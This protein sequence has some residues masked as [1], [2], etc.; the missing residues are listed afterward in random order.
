[1]TVYEV[2]LVS[3]NLRPQEM[4]LQMADTL[5][6]LDRISNDIFNK[7]GSRIQESRLRIQKIHQR[8]EAAQNKIGTMTG[9]R[10]ATRIFSSS[11]FPGVFQSSTVE[12]F[13]ESNIATIKSKPT[14]EN[15]DTPVDS[16]S[17]FYPPLSRSGPTINLL[18]PPPKSVSELLIF[19]TEDLVF[20]DKLVSERIPKATRRKHDSSEAAVDGLLGDAPWSIIQRESGQINPHNYAYIP[21]IIGNS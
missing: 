8:V 20:K 11:R 15:A 2:P 19:N 1:M 6:H 12:L 7:V 16:D 13:S 21:G 17:T 10:K 5:D 18:P 9:S 3:S 14:W 4:I